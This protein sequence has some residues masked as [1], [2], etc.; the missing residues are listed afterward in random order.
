MFLLIRWRTTP[1]QWWKG[2]L[3]LPYLVHRAKT[4]REEGLRQA[5]A[6]QVPTYLRVRSAAHRPLPHVDLVDLLEGQ[7]A[8][9]AEAKAQGVPKRGVSRAAAELAEG[10]SSEHQPPDGE[11][12]AVLRHVVER[13]PTELYVELMAGL[14]IQGLR[15]RRMAQVEEDSEAEEDPD[16]QW[17]EID[18]DDY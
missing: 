17:P 18:D 7:K 15:E 11:T 12:H 1:L 5:T 14:D 2:Q 10:A 9:D 16:L 4:L 3:E 13:M 8:D 6:T